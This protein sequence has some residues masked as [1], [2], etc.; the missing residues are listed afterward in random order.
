VEEFVVWLEVGGDGGGASAG[1]VGVGGIVGEEADVGGEEDEGGKCAWIES[2]SD[3]CIVAARWEEGGRSGVLVLGRTSR[4]SLMDREK[5]Y[6]QMDSV[7][8]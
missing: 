1:G 7:S 2:V 5:T 8:A 4:M 6:Q 3:L